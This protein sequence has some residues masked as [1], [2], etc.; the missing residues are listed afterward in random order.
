MKRFF[1]IFAAV[2]LVCTTFVACEEKFD[3]YTPA[4][5]ET[6][7]QVYFSKDAA[8]TI[9]ILGEESVEIPVMRAVNG[10]GVTANITATLTA[11]DGKAVAGDGIKVTVPVTVKGI[12]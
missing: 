2:A 4:A 12:L 8:S 10:A 5:Q 6:T 9:N 1:K 3:E 11:V 7:A